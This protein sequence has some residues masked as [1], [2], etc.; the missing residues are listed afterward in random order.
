MTIGAKPHLQSL[1]GQGR[2]LLVNVVSHFEQ[3]FYCESER[4]RNMEMRIFV[5]RIGCATVP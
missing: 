1:S 5:P 2:H 3:P 4:P